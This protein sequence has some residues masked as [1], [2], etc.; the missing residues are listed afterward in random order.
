MHRLLTLVA[1][2]ALLTGVLQAQVRFTINAASD[3]PV[4]GWQKMDIDGRS[5]WVNP[6][7][8]LTSADIQG[9]E[10]GTDRN[11]GNY[12][13][14]AFTDAGAKKIRDLTTVQMNK[15][16]AMV[17]DGKVISAPGVRSVITSDG[18]ITW[19]PRGLTTEEVRRILTSVNQ[20]QR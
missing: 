8:A 2:S 9:A 19:S 5:V 11:F 17:L 7:P 13:K 18:M 20:R 16:I 6:A 1:V 12:V 15:L 4:A 14:V 3:D 10:P